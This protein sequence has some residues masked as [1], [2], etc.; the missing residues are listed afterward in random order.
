MTSEHFA[1]RSGQDHLCLPRACCVPPA[2]SNGETN[3]LFCQIDVSHVIRKG[4]Q[5]T[6]HGERKGNLIW[7]GIR[8]CRHIL[9]LLIVIYSKWKFARLLMTHYITGRVIHCGTFVISALAVKGNSSRFLSSTLISD[10]RPR[11]KGGRKGHF[12][13]RCHL[14]SWRFDCWKRR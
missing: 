11:D 13:I 8:Q 1:K 12:L 4:H 10:N 2:W 9:L 5:N 6:L 14:Y 7:R 3:F